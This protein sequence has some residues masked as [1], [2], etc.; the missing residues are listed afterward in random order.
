MQSA[1]KHAGAKG[2]LVVTS[3]GNLHQDIDA[4][5]RYPASLPDDIVLTAAATTSDG[6]LW[7]AA[8]ALAISHAQMPTSCVGTCPALGTWLERSLIGSM[9]TQGLGLQPLLRLRVWLRMDAHL[10]CSD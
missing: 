2:V 8:S 1:V 6:S 9:H 3:A 4:T 10:V 7:Y 5:P